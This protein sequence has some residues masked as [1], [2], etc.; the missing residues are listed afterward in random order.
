MLAQSIPGIRHHDRDARVHFDLPENR[1]ARFRHDYDPLPP[2]STLPR[3]EVAQGVF[4]GVSKSRNFLR[5][6]SEPNPA[7]HCAGVPALVVEGFRRVQYSWWNAV[8]YRGGI[9]FDFHSFFKSLTSRSS[10]RY[11]Q[12]KL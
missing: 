10:S 4:H 11:S 5:E 12:M 7:R 1:L 8:R 9:S 2:G 3:T 6:C